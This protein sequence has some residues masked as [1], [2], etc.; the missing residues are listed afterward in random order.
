MSS[1]LDGDGTPDFD[2]Y[3]T[4]FAFDPDGDGLES[5]KF[6]VVVVRWKQPG[7]GMRQVVATAVRTNAEVFRP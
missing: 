5:F 1:D 2:R 3:W 4:V 6:V 7:W